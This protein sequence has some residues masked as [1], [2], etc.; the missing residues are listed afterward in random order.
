M[1]RLIEEAR[2]LDVTYEFVTDLSPHHPGSYSHSRRHIEVLDGMSYTKTLCAFAHELG[3]ATLQHELTMFDHINEKHERAADE[4]AAHFLIDPT[5]YKAAEA[6]FGTRTD[7][8]A[9]ELGVLKR[10]VEAF[11]Q[12]L[13][14]VGNRVY[15]HPKMGVGQWTAEYIA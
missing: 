2:A 10:T 9:Q 5:E 4:W 1:Q 8:I 12:S 14:R 15:V 3:H 13:V 6:R 11:E 7:W